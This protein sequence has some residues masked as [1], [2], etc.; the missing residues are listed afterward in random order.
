MPSYP[1][2]K[3]RRKIISRLGVAHREGA[4]ADVVAELEID[5][6]E[7]QLQD[8][9]VHL[10]S[11]TGFDRT[12]CERLARLLVGAPDITP[13]QAATAARLLSQTGGREVA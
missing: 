9:I 12:R 2:S 10:Q 1:V 11:M 5:L 13:E 6:A 7:A 8:H 3:H 4:S